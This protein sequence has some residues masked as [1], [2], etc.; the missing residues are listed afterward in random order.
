MSLVEHE[1]DL[2]RLVYLQDTPRASHWP[3]NAKRTAK[4]TEVPNRKIQSIIVH[5]SAGG[6]FSGIDAVEKLGAYF[7]APPKTTVDGKVIGGG[8]GWPGIPYTFVIPALPDVA[9]GKIVVYRVWPD[10]MR[11]WHTGGLFNSH[12]VAVCVAGHYAS[13]ADPI[14]RQSA[15]PRP[16]DAAVTALD[17]LTD[18]LSDRYRLQLRPGVLVAHREV[19]QTACPGDYL[20]GWVRQKRGELVAEPMGPEDRRPLETLNAVQ[21]ALLELGYDLGPTGADGAWGLRTARAIKLFQADAGLAADGICGVKT[22]AA[23]RVALARAK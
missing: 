13:S 7:T 20:A 8:R 5:H 22:I 6:F 2:F 21:L 15:R 19:G 18:Y 12:G 23:L 10:S 1:T 11:T 4:F 14:A 17:L 3:Y 9:D 16:D